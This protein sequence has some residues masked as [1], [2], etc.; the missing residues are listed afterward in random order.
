[1][2][3]TNNLPDDQLLLPSGILITLNPQQIEAIETIKAWLQTKEQMFVLEGFAGTGK[4][5]SIKKLLDSLKLDAVVSAPTHKALKVIS[6]FTG[7]Q[8]RTLQSLLGLSPNLNVENF[9]INNLQFDPTGRDEISLYEILIIDEA[10]MINDDLFDYLK[11]IAKRT[12]VK[13]IF[14]GDSAQIPPIKEKIS[15]VFTEKLS[16]F[17][18]TKI[19]RQN[20]GN[21]LLILND[22]LRDSTKSLDEVEIK[23]IL[24]TLGEGLEVFNLE[25]F[26]QQLALKFC[27]KEYIENPLYAKL[28][29][30]TNASVRQWNTI[31]RQMRFPEET[32]PLVIGDVLMS[33]SNIGRDATGAIIKNSEDYL[34][35][36]VEWAMSPFNV[37]GY[38]TGLQEVG[39][40]T[41]HEIFIVEPTLKGEWAYL[42]T[43]DELLQKA[44]HFAPKSKNR[45]KCFSEEY[46]PFKEN[47]SLMQDCTSGSK[48]TKD[49]DYGYAVSCHKAQGS[50]YINTFISEPNINKNI[51]IAEKNKIK[52]VAY[53]RASHKAHIYK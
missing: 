44:L 21:P 49:I 39:G 52:Y 17:S 53:S 38:I 13:I 31:I 22:M 32:L 50:T 37:P 10:S 28:L 24:N 1:M 35:K 47:H 42:R 25:E 26:K 51:N 16:R 29:T 36:K 8:G 34:V 12:R 18:L 7:E 48:K 45:R 9:D 30:W 43:H 40:I 15:K 14:I 6:K 3:L 23:T 33:Y 4:S 19:E 2:K 5:C 27:S 20:D 46:F 11:I 41:V